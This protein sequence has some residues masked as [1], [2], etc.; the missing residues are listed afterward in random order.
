MSNA[1]RRQLY[2]LY[3]EVRA[4]PAAYSYVIGSTPFQQHLDLYSQLLDS[5]SP[6]LPAI[7]FDDGHVSNLTFAAPLLAARNL[8]AH[9]FITAGWTAHRSGYMDWQQLRELHHMGH[10]IGA[11]GWSHKLL[12]HCSP[13]ELEKELTHARLTLE[14]QLSTSITTMSLPGGRSNRRVF[15]A[16]AAA[17]Y[18]RVYT[19]LPRQEPL[20]PG[21]TIGRLNIRGNAHPEWVAKLFN[22][23]SPVLASVMRAA[24]MKAA[25]QTLL[26]DNL[27]ARIWAF[28]NRSEPDG[29]SASDPSPHQGHS[30]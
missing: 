13:P 15:A 20:S 14:D 12:T 27:Y 3:H 23:S 6:L 10:T 7:T 9:F 30:A 21:R 26:G 19:S 4:E 11:H 17:G 24:R 28:A 5:D 8:K 18:T 16:C 2:L 1:P 29:D 22:P 25:V